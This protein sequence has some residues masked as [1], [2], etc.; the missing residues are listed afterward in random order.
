MQRVR[1]SSHSPVQKLGDSQLSSSPKFRLATVTRRPA[2]PEPAPS[3]EPAQLIPGLPDDVALNCLLRLPVGTH[4]SCSSVCRS[5]RQLLGNK[6]RFFSQRKR[7]G[8]S[9]PWLFVLAFD[10]CTGKIQWQVLDLTLLSWHTIAAMPSRDRLSPHG[11]R[12]IAVPDEAALLVCGGTVSGMDCPLDTVVRFDLQ[13]DRWTTM[14]RMHTPRSFFA[15]GLIGGLV[16][17]A[18]GSSTNLAE[19]NSAEVLDLGRGEWRPVA[20][21]SSSMIAYDSAV[22]DGKLLVTEGWVWP[23]VFSPRGQ[24]YDPRADVWEPMAPGLREGWTGASVVVGGHLFVICEHESLRMKVYDMESDSWETVDGSP[25]PKEIAKPFSV[26]AGDHK[27]CVVGRDL[28]A[29]VG[30]VRR[31]D[32]PGPEEGKERRKASFAVRWQIVDSPESLRGVTP[33]SALVLY[34]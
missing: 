12:C 5:W 24:S 33:S 18:G 14:S 34:G 22:L 6:K 30:H 9:S 29:A 27:I 3:M 11:I 16:Y 8:I 25:V 32:H 28:H 31:T 17:V 10:R 7:L 21:M 13:R 1:I 19:L 4:P 15:G 2:P 23:F 26:N 20:S